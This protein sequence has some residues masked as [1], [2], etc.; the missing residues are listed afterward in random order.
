VWP[1]LQVIGGAAVLRFDADL[2][3]ESFEDTRTRPFVQG[4]GGVTF[5]VGDGWG[6][7][8]SGDYRRLF[9]DEEEDFDTGR[10]DVRG[11]FGVT[12]ILD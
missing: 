2:V 10:N 8:V 1:Y 6:L 4:G 3:D 12:M 7:F 5:V 11:L 9:L